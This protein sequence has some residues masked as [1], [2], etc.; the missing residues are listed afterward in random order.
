MYS[1]LT[2]PLMLPRHQLIFMQPNFNGLLLC[3]LLFCLPVEGRLFLTKWAVLSLAFTLSPCTTKVRSDSLDRSLSFPHIFYSLLLASVGGYGRLSHPHP[4]T[5]TV[6]TWPHCI[7]R[8]PIYINLQ[9]FGVIFCGGGGYW[10]L[11]Y[12]KLLFKLSW[13]YMS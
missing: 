7:Y 10:L 11:S 3:L 9:H 5:H 6:S 1:D 4:H 13:C 8:Y 2:D 12:N